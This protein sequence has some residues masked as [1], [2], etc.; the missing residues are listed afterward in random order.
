MSRKS[1]DSW[2]HSIIR[3]QDITDTRVSFTF[4]HIPYISHTDTVKPNIPNIDKRAPPAGNS[5]KNKR[6]LF[7]TDSVHSSTPEHIFRS[8][9]G[10]I[11]V[12]KVN[13][14]FKDILDYE[15]YFCGTDTV[16]L[17]CGVNDLA[18]YGQTA[19]SLADFVLPNLAKCCQRYPNTKFVYN[20]VLHSN[21]ANN[22][23]WLNDEI[24]LFNF[25]MTNFCRSVSNI[26][27]FDSH[28][29]LGQSNFRRVWDPRDKNGI[30]I[31]L[32]ARKLVIRELVDCVNSLSGSSYSRNRICRWPMFHR[33]T[34]R[35][36][37]ER[38]F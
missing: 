21:Y 1:Q 30:H 32:E 13:F 2:R 31:T 8:I 18:R 20:S 27:Y 16:I 26:Y 33:T 23:A 37:G 22:Y 38:A 17:S 11:C 36:L 24:D 6:V 28:S 12:K 15:P 4:R 25:Y 35:W 10:C 19:N 3:D 29:L 34:P 5:I 14:Q 7:L 9:P